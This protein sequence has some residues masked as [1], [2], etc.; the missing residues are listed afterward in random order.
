M[1][2]KAEGKMEGFEIALAVTKG[3]LRG[4]SPSN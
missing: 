4:V 2:G 1:E 3:L